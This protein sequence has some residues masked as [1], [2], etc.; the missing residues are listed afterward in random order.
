ML[1]GFRK[2]LPSP[3]RMNHCL[4]SPGERSGLLNGTKIVAHL[5]KGQEAVTSLGFGFVMAECPP[6]EDMTSD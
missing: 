3:M 2:K 1:W 5:E 4:D 6:T